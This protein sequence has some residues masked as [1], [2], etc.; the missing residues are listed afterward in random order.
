MKKFSKILVSLVVTMMMLT[1]LVANAENYDGYRPIQGGTT[2]FKKYLVMNPGTEVPNA[3]FTFTIEAGQAAAGTATTVKQLA[4]LNPELVIASGTDVRNKATGVGDTSKEFYVDFKST[5]VATDAYGAE[6]LGD[7]HGSEVAAKKDITLSFA[8]IT[9]TEPGVYRY[10]ITE[11]ATSNADVTMDTK[12]KRTLDVYVVDNN[13]TLEVASYVM[14]EGEL[15][16]PAKVKANAGDISD[17]LDDH[18]EPVVPAE[19]TPA[20][21]ENPTPEEAAAIEAYNAAK[22]AH[23]EWEADK[24][25][26][27]AAADAAALAANPNGAEA[28]L[29][30][31]DKY[32]NKYLTYDLVV[33]KEVTGNQGS[34]DQYFKFTVTFSDGRPNAIIDLV[35]PENLPTD[36]EN[37]TETPNAATTYTK[38]VIYTANSRDDDATLT[39]QQ[40]KLN[41][42]GGAEVVFYLQHGEQAKFLNIPE[43]YT[44]PD[45]GDK[46]ITKYKVEEAESGQDGYTTTGEVTTAKEVSAVE[47]RFDEVQEDSNLD[48]QKYTFVHV[49]GGITYTYKYDATNSKWVQY[50]PDG[51]ESQVTL[52]YN[53]STTNVY[54]TTE[55]VVNHRNGVLPTGVAAAASTGLIILGIGAA[56]M[57]V[58][59]RKK[60][61]DED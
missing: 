61:D 14:Y 50:E 34:K 33:K 39:G 48:E 26:A 23:T 15:T 51:T 43:G 54:L 1:G 41:A 28:G 9:F 30:K 47:M 46:K 11:T 4:G 7:A 42:N 27:Q 13:G 38:G 16:N 57:F 36:W 18:Q 31:S 55:K 45:T 17:W 3:T 10:I 22:A 53:A 2:A 59:G 19:P 8:D 35:M 21:P 32:V 58:F 40:I 6:A 24:A 29:P 37:S 52:P 5:D 44:N 25:A 49:E 60:D 56:G 20:D 12:T